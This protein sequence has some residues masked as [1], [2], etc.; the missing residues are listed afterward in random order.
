MR[1][2]FVVILL[3]IAT[4]MVQA[5][6][7]QARWRRPKYHPEHGDIRGVFNHFQR[8]DPAKRF[9]KVEDPNPVDPITQQRRSR[10]YHFKFGP[11]YPNHHKHL[12]DADQ[13]EPP[14]HKRWN[15]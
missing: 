6:W 10:Q 12:Q 15:P 9:E 14:R 8:F 3:L 2:L 11:I 5:A 4:N 13:L 1:F 7:P